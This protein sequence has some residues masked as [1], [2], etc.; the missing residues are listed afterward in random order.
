M[1]ITF[2]SAV[3]VFF[4]L[5][6]NTAIIASNITP[7]AIPL[8]MPAFVPVLSPE[9]CGMT[10]G[11]PGGDVGLAVVEKELPVHKV[12]PED[13][14]SLTLKVFILNGVCVGV[15][16][17]VAANWNRLE[18][19]LQ[20]DFSPQHHLPSLHF[21]TGALSTC[22]YQLVSSFTRSFSNL[23]PRSLTFAKLQTSLRQSSLCHVGS[24]HPCRHQTFTPAL[25][26]S[27]AS[28]F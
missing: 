13:G 7:T 1:W 6:N 28:K 24:V 23:V 14:V 21:C 12:V 18:V 3:L 4:N 2:S 26:P 9:L 5:K 25:V 20:H 8:P 19:I 10:A 11:L 15:G 22:H 17:I 16:V 27:K